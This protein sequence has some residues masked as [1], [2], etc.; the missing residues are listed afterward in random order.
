MR[1]RGY[2]LVELLVVVGI[3]AILAAMIM[4]VLTQA[5]DTARMRVCADGMRQLG[6][7]IARYVDDHDGLGLPQSPATFK[8]PWVFY[9]KPLCPQYTGQSLSQLDPNPDVYPNGKIPSRIYNASPTDRPKLLW[10]CPGDFKFGPNLEQCPCWWVFGSSY[11]Y[12]GPTAYLQS[13]DPTDKD[14]MSKG[15]AYPRKLGLWK[16]P[17]RDML[18]A[19]FYEDYHSGTRAARYT[20][21]D[22][23]CLNPPLYIITNSTNVL[24]LDQHVKAVT[25]KQ[26]QEYRDYTT[27]L[28]NPYYSPGKP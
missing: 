25:P 5:K 9:P 23:R 27:T 14:S 1:H 13:K 16:N 4:P 8:N 3:I 12:P 11:M 10:I 22:P 2:T 24:F 28:D 6:L 17:K 21:A 7:A 26:K 19:D 20:T 15:D 18:L